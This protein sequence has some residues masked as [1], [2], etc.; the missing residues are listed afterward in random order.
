MQVYR[1]ALK[2]RYYAKM[3][4]TRFFVNLFPDEEKPFDHSIRFHADRSRHCPGA[5]SGEL[6]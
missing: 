5:E 3:C 6:I 4:S 2:K 1:F